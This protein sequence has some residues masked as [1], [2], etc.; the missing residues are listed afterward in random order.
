MQG[1]EFQ[2]DKEYEE[3]MKKLKFAIALVLVEL[4]PYMH[5]D[6]FETGRGIYPH[7]KPFKPI[8]RNIKRAVREFG[9]EE[10]LEWI[11]LAKKKEINSRYPFNRLNVLMVSAFYGKFH[12]LKFEHPLDDSYFNANNREMQENLKILVE[13]DYT[14]SYLIIEYTPSEWEANKEDILDEI[15]RKAVEVMRE[16]IS[17]GDGSEDGDWAIIRDAAADEAM[18]GE[19]DSELHEYAQ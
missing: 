1:E 13:H 19:R 11:E 16:E 6:Y 18:T 3:S 15:F 2:G 14:D 17:D 8:I 4:T 12:L 10:I 9:L 7:M 5:K